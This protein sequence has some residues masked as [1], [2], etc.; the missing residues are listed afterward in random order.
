MKTK[1]SLLAILLN[2]SLFVSGQQLANTTWEV[3]DTTGAFFLYFQFG[4][5]TVGYS[6][7]NISFT[8]VAVYTESGSQFMINDLP[9]GPCSVGDTGVYSFQILNDTLFFTVISEPC[10]GRDGTFANYTWVSTTAKLMKNST[11]DLGL[12][13]NP[14]MESVFLKASAVEAGTEI[15]LLDSYGRIVS[16]FYSAENGTT[17]I[18]VSELNPGLYFVEIT[19]L[20]SRNSFVKN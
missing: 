12:F 18:P 10:T 14:A 20:N 6:A 8:D 15:R 2:L 19:S 9:S 17:E 5:D 7:D 11:I 3:Y 1:I 16:V 4:S 13:P